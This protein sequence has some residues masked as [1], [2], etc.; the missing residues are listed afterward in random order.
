KKR[1]SND[2]ENPTTPI[3]S[4]L[5]KNVTPR[6]SL[7]HSNSEPI[8]PAQK[9][10]SSPTP[11]QNDQKNDGLLGE[12]FNELS[13]VGTKSS[14]PDQL[15]NRRRLSSRSSTSRSSGGFRN[16]ISKKKDLHDTSSST[17]NDRSNNSNL[18][19]KKQ[20]DSDDSETE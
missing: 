19:V 12:I 17:S 7:N 10:F 2:N 6:L 4:T 11:V 13:L 8:I 3:P 5:T 15:D 9:E 16:L 1:S 18:K 20:L 14:K